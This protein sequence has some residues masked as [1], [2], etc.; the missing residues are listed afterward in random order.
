M[1]AKYRVGTSL[2]RILTNAMALRRTRKIDGARALKF[3][4]NKEDLSSERFASIVS[5]FSR[6]EWIASCIPD[7]KIQFMHEF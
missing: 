5:E 3:Q 6:V 4:Y 7:Q 2:K 1:H